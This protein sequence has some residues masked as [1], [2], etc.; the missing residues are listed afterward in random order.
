MPGINTPT[1]MR[2]VA[3]S[4]PPGA[5]FNRAVAAK[6]A[7]DDGTN[8]ALMFFPASRKALATDVTQQVWY[9]EGKVSRAEAIAQLSGT[10][11][12]TF[13]VRETVRGAERETTHTIDVQ[14]GPRVLHI[15]VRHVQGP[16]GTL[17]RIA[18]RDWLFER[19]YDVVRFCSYNPFTMPDLPQPVALNSHLITWDGPVDSS[20]ESSTDTTPRGSPTPSRPSSMMLEI[21]AS[22]RHGGKAAPC[23]QCLDAPACVAFVPCGHI[24]MCA[25]CGTYAKLGG[26]PC[27]ICRVAATG[28]LRVYLA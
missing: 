20:T 13:M 26:Q 18:N 2:I 16:S 24:C 28:T 21:V 3:F 10:E 15:L 14:G 1:S 11:I 5:N 22:G 17:Y 27:P 9:R 8:E 25:T 23:C 6:V 4:F 19:L 12:G 7:Y